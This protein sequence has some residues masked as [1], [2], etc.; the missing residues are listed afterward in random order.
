VESIIRDRPTVP[1]AKLVRLWWLD[2]PDCDLRAVDETLSSS[3]SNRTNADAIAE[4][5]GLYGADFV[6]HV[7]G[8][9]VSAI[10]DR[11]EQRLFL[12]N[13]RFGKHQ[14][15]I[16]NPSPETLFFACEVK[17]IIPIAMNWLQLSMQA[18]FDFLQYQFLVGEETY[19]ENVSLLPQASILKIDKTGTHIQKY[20]VPVPEPEDS[21]FSEKNYEIKLHELMSTAVSR[22]IHGRKAGQL[23]SGGLDSRNIAVHLPK[24]SRPYHTFTFGD[25]NSE[26]V[27]IAQR[28]ASEN[29]FQFHFR[30]ITSKVIPDFAALSAWILEGNAS[31]VT[32]QNMLFLDDA[33]SNGVEVVLDG[34]IGNTLFDLPMPYPLPVFALLSLPFL[35]SLVLRLLRKSFPEDECYRRIRNS[36]TTAI[37]EDKV[38]NILSAPALNSIATSSKPLRNAVREAASYCNSI[39][40]MAYFVWLTEYHRRS[41][42]LPQNVCRWRVELVDP[43]LD[44]DLVDFLLKLPYK[45]KLWRRLVR[46]EVAALHPSNIPLH[47]SVRPTSAHNISLFV[48]M[49]GKRIPLIRN[50]IVRERAR[51]MG[52]YVYIFKEKRAFVENILLDERAR[53]RGIFKVDRIQ[54]LIEEQMSSRGDHIRLL[55]RLLS[56]EL[57]FRSVED[58]YGV[59]IF[60]LPK[61]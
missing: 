37:M 26:D 27:K 18:I 56:L 43:F 44:Y 8:Q 25:P 42:V 38:L 49:A 59:E 19:F 32:G 34:V 46:N 1:Q 15:Y 12:V 41:C 6:K 4:C 10:W 55:L 61:N 31:A 3:M 36:I 23:L 33:E 17:C 13:D 20:W 50:L 45:Y 52:Q 7:K 29:G 24:S 2:V 54:T 58:R 47:A 53:S 22:A 30:P 9:F 16:W 5:Y 40:D 14:L 39:L 51:T 28:F 48:I 57:W 11:K 35:G 21:H 60:R